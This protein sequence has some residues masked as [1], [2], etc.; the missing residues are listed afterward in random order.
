MAVNKC[1]KP[2]ADPQ[3]VKQEL[4]AHDVV[5]EEFGGDVQAI[6]ISALKV[7]LSYLNRQTRSRSGFVRVQTLECQQ[8]YSLWFVYKGK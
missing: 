1:D 8:V 7:R 5:C 4:L 2:Q 6:H 3:R